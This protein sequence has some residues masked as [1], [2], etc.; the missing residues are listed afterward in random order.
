[1]DTMNGLHLSRLEQTKLM[2]Q[3]VDQSRVKPMGILPQVKTSISGIVY[4][5]DYI[6]FQ[7][8]TPNTFYP[9]LLGRP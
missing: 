8:S 1:M 3:M 7:P 9:T 4:F 2:L 6:V 5:I